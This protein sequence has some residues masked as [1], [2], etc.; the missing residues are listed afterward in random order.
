[1]WYWNKANFEGL[2]AIA[3]E[4]AGLPDMADFGRYCVLRSSGLR[5][6]ALA[7]LQAFVAHAEP[8]AFVR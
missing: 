4:A 3:A 8:L 5:K 2:E 7:A 1:M 6:Q